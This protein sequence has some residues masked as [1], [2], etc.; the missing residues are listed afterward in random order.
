[1]ASHIHGSFSM[2]IDFPFP[3]LET[4]GLLADLKHR[5]HLKLLLLLQSIYPIA[6]SDSF[7]RTELG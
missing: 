2:E 3:G 7:L 1:M 4:A 6:P 5:V